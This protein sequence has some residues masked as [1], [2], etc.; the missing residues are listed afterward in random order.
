MSVRDSK[1]DLS[2]SV[3]ACKTVSA[4]SFLRYALLVGRYASKEINMFGT[5]TSVSP[6]V[7]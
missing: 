3:A 2:L 1:F 7:Q 5:S 4:V 6:V